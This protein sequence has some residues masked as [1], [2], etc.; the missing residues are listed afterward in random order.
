MATS[1]TALD[2]AIEIQKAFE[3]IKNFS[4]YC[5]NVDCDEFLDLMYPKSHEGYREEKLL[6]MRND[7]CSYFLSLSPENQKKLVNAVLQRYKHI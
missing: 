6:K 3:A 4:L 7:P 2:S 5:Y 1:Q